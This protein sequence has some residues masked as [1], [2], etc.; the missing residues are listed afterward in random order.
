MRDFTPSVKLPS[1]AA[2][3][4]IDLGMRAFEQRYV[5]YPE[6][7]E[8]SSVSAVSETLLTGEP[9]ASTSLGL[10]RSARTLSRV[11]EVGKFTCRVA[12]FDLKKILL[13]LKPASCSSLHACLPV[14]GVID[15]WE[16]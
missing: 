12:N 8:V 1:A 3:A 13:A 11:T 10:L 15:D 9:M 4:Y 16:A 5:V 7:G 2:Q 14:A 6:E